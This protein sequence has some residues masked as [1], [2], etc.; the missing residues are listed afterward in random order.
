MVRG[1]PS[2]MKVEKIPLMGLC[3]AV[4]MV[5]PPKTLRSRVLGLQ[6]QQQLASILKSPSTVTDIGNRLG[7]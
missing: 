1:M 5:P 6:Q 7:H 3:S 4:V 2:R